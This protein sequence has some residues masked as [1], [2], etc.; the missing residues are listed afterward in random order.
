MD[1]PLKYK[2]K[3]DEIIEEL[4]NEMG[5]I[6]EIKIKQF[7]QQKKHN[8]LKLCKIKEKNNKI[9]VFNMAKDYEE[10]NGIYDNINK[11]NK[12]IIDLQNRDKFE[13]TKEGII[14]VDP[15][16]DDINKEPTPV[17]FGKCIK[18]HQYS[19]IG[20]KQYLTTMKI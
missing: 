8:T 20:P 18:C 7:N 15:I 9:E 4:E 19:D 16:N 14:P 3:F 17:I 2:R 6:Y 13:D 12:K 10:L 5:N 1:V 11:V